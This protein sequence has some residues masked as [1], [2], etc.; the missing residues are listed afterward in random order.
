MDTKDMHHRNAGV[1]PAQDVA[2]GL[3]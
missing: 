3:S 1:V 2:I